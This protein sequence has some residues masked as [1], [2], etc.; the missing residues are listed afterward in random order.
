MAHSRR[1]TVPAIGIRSCNRSEIL[2]KHTL[3]TDVRQC[4]CF[5]V[6]VVLACLETCFY[7]NLFEKYIRGEI[8]ARDLSRSSAVL[9]IVAIDDVHGS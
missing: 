1:G 7:H 3:L 4:S 6:V 2:D 9:G 8:L 5:L